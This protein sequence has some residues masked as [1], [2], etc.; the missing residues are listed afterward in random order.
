[1]IA[2]P[3]E[4]VR[5][6]AWNVGFERRDQEWMLHDWD[7]WVRNPH[8]TGK[9][10]PH[11]EDATLDEDRASFLADAVDDLRADALGNGGFFVIDDDIPF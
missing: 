9:P 4:S 8:F 3:S 1:M 6:W 2:T 11:P 5:E 10:G 7:V